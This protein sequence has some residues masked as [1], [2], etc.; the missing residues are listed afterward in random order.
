LIPSCIESFDAVP[1]HHKYSFGHILLFLSLI[2][3]AATSFRCASNVID[4]MMTSLLLPFTSPS[5]YSGRLWLLRVGYYKLNRQKQ[6]ADDWVWIVD[7]TIQTGSEKCFVILGI[8]LCS[9]PLRGNCVSHEDV[10]PISLCPVK[11]SNGDIVY[12]Q[13]DKAIDKTGIPKEIIGDQ[14]SDLASGIKKFCQ[15]HPET[16]YIYDIKHKTAAVLKHEFEHDEKW[17]EF[18]KLAAKTKLDVQQTPLASLSPPNQRTKSRYM[19]IDIL[20][21]WG[22]KIL[23]FLDKQQKEASQ[24]FDQYQLYGKL[25]WIMTFREELKEWE[26]ILQII[27][28]TESFVRKNGL[29]SD[30]HLELKDIMALMAHTERNKIVREQLLAFVLE[31]SL[32][33]KPK[34]RLLGSSEVIES[35]FG[36]L[37]RLEND[38]AKSGFTGLLLSIAAMVATT[39]KDVVEEALKTV[40]TKE[41]YAWCKINIGQSVQSMR[42]EAF[43]FYDKTEQK[44]DQIVG[45]A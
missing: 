16:C 3:S 33:A 13:L 18:T 29:Y 4:I 22:L 45:G 23:T 7:H 34:E 35:V 25:G 2:L 38:Q 17:L 11:Q 14:G 28:T 36:K 20:I 15:A 44:R 32:K 21:N 41:I 12:Q 1:F 9:L 40:H 43:S 10:E 31:E 26:D 6:K 24:K 37:K 27:S 30:C 39:T 5:W 42:K 8:R 19:N